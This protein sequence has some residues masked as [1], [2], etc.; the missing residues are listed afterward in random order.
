MSEASVFVEEA[1]GWARELVVS[2]SRMPGDYKNAMRRVARKAAVP[3]HLIWSLHYRPPKSIDVGQWAALG[4]FYAGQR[5][6]FNAER[7]AVM[8]RTALGALL[9]GAADR[10][11]GQDAGVLKDRGGGNAAATSGAIAKG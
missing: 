10:L 8:P 3:F 4:N 2:D 6:K 7:A 11:A 9:L 5:Q 1:K